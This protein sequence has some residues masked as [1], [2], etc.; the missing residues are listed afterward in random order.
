VRQTLNG[1]P[2]LFEI[3]GPAFQRALAKVGIKPG[4]KLAELRQLPP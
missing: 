4:A 3:R 2:Q 1:P